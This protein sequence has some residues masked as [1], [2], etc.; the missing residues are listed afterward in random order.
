[1]SDRQENITVD[2]KIDA[3]SLDVTLST[4]SNF[5]N[6]DLIERLSYDELVD[7]FQSQI[8]LRQRVEQIQRDQNIIV[9][10]TTGDILELQKKVAK[11]ERERTIDE[12]KALFRKN[13]QILSEIGQLGENWNGYGASSIPQNIIFRCL[14]II[15][16]SELNF[17]PEIFPT[18]RPSIHFVYEPDKNHYL[19]LD[20][21]ETNITCYL[22]Q[23]T[24]IEEY[25]EL[26]TEEAITLINDF[27]S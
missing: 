13:N 21:L 17:Q 22:R 6:I 16:S 18:A 14:N 26:T 3:L 15:S 9:T 11:L 23:F 2:N 1:M 4:S 12:E 8:A 19:E 25:S 7:I 27:Q 5:H 24:D 20:I 10:S